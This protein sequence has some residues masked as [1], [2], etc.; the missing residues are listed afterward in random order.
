M[1][2]MLFIWIP[3]SSP[4]FGVGDDGSSQATLFSIATI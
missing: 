2:N 1:A 4:F 3:K